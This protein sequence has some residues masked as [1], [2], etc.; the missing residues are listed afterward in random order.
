MFRWVP[1]A[2]LLVVSR[3]G[4]GL[5]VE[6]DGLQPDEV[7]GAADAAGQHEEEDD[8]EEAAHLLEPGEGQEAV[9]V[10]GLGVAPEALPEGVLQG[11]VVQGQVGPADVQFGQ[12]RRQ[13]GGGGRPDPGEPP[14]L[15][16]RR[17]GGGRGRGP[18][19][20]RGVHRGRRGSPPAACLP[21]GHGGAGRAVRRAL[22]T[23]RGGGG[24]RVALALA[25]PALTD[26]G[27]LLLRRGRGGPRVVRHG[28]GPGERRHRHRLRQLAFSLNSINYKDSCQCY[29]TVSLK[30]CKKAPKKNRR[31]PF[32]LK[33]IKTAC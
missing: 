11:S 14:P 15:L 13:Q 30:F 24:G 8:P 6:V 16:P 3:N 7:G 12:G 17:R 2:L 31:K 27:I 18:P 1:H 10:G 21:G 5:L 23:R 33:F 26:L 25:A 9:D 28:A 19:G 32:S 20:G 29:H 22:A 4:D